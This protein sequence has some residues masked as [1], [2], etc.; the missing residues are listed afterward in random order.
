MWKLADVLSLP[1]VPMICDFNK[2]LRLIP[3]TYTIS[4]VAEGIV[5]EKELKPVIF[6]SIDPGQFGFIP[7]S[8]TTFAFISMLHHWLRATDG[9]GS[10]VRTALLDHRKEFDLVDHHLLIAKLF[11]PGVIDFLRDYRRD[12][13]QRVELNSNCY[14]SWLD[15]PAGVPQDTRLGP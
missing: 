12:R 13:Q 15:V 9:N 3:L 7:G 4:K 14:S 6:S 10:T 5:I 8:T 1:K 2:D 11:S